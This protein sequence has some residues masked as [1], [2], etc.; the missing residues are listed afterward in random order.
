ME[1]HAHQVADADVV[2]ARR[3]GAADELGDRAIEVHRART[4]EEHAV[5]EPVAEHV[6][7]RV[8]RDAARHQVADGDVP[9]LVHPAAADDLGHR[10]AE[11]ERVARVHTAHQVVA[12]E[13]ARVGEAAEQGHVLNQP[14]VGAAHHVPAVE[15]QVGVAADG[16]HI[17]AGAV[18]VDGERARGEEAA[19][20][21][22]IT[23]DEDVRAQAH[24]GRVVHVEVV[25]VGRCV[26]I[27]HLRPRATEAHEVAARH[28]AT[29]VVAVENTG[30]RERAQHVDVLVQRHRNRILEAHIVEVCD[31]RA[32]D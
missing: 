5:V 19:V 29:P 15:A 2:E 13:S 25:E 1:R 8:E 12:V 20:E 3:D 26:G 27:N 16:L 14:H 21:V 17:A 23:R 4:G 22:I 28:T 30:V 6:N 24:A 32:A 7:R 31:L 11:G 10:A 18:E 9:E